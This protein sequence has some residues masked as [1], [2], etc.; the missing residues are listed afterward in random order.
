[1]TLYWEAFGAKLGKTLR[2]ERKALAF[3]ARVI[4]PQFA[5]A[6]RDNRGA[7][8]GIAGYKTADGALVGG[9]FGDLAATYGIV[10]ACWRA[11]L[12]SLVERKLSHGVLLMDGI[13]VTAEARGKG[14]G[15]SLL[16]AIKEE[17]ATQG[18]AEVRLDVIN[19][20]PRARA[21]YERSGFSP[22]ETQHLGPFKHIFGFSSSLEMR[23]TLQAQSG[24]CRDAAN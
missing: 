11:A 12:L 22:G 20:N 8:L 7:L 3:L 23:Y 13:F 4:D 6:A 15:T 10:G 9:G 24:N 18:C 5:I 17:A 14:V 21:L 19:T 2:P 1:A 16:D